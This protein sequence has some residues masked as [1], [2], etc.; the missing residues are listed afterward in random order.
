MVTAEFVC[1]FSLGSPDMA[2]SKALVATIAGGTWFGR[3]V[4][5]LD[6]IRRLGIGFGVVAI[7]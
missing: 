2:A 4:A 1:P 5:W 6:P 3:K 7:T